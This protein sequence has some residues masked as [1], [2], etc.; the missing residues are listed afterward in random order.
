MGSNSRNYRVHESDI[1]SI[2]DVITSSGARI[3][4]LQEVPCEWGATG[5]TTPITSMLNVPRLLSRD[6]G[7]SYIFGSAIEDAHYPTANQEYLEWGTIDKWTNN[8]KKHGEFGNVLLLKVPLVGTARNLPLPMRPKDEP[9]ECLRAEVSVPG[10][11]R[12]VILYATHFQHEGAG[13]RPAQMKFLLKQIASEPAEANVFLLGDFNY[14]AGSPVENVIEM[15]TQQGLRDLQA[16]FATEHHQEPEF[17]FPADKP[18]RRIDYILC[19]GTAKPIK[20]QVVP[21]LASDHRALRID[22]SLE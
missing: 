8:G 17:T 3:A 4:A 15:A 7:A 1:A 22:V 13:S 6:T 21:S 11:T 20:V 19:R 18:N 9:R 16:E 5:E 12:P 10:A 14:A 2:A